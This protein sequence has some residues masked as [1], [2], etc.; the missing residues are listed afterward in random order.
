MTPKLPSPCNTHAELHLQGDGLRQRNEHRLL[1]KADAQLA[2]QRTHKEGGLRA[3][4]RREQLV[5]ELHFGVLALVALHVGDFLK[6]LEDAL[7]RNCADSTPASECPHA[8][9]HSSS[10]GSAT[11]QCSL[12]YLLV[13][14]YW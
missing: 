10:A 7:H 14:A 6:A 4:G 8:G 5:D 12:P 11:Q 2:L 3:V 13:F 1:R 9:Q